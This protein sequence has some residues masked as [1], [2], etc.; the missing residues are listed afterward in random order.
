MRDFTATGGV[1][2]LAGVVQ[3][4]VLGE[5]CQVCRVVILVVADAGLR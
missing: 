3:V 5:G 4:V 2:V 1:A